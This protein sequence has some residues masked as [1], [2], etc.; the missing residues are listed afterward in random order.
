MFVLVT[1]NL[2]VDQ[3]QKEKEKGKKE[4]GKQK[5]MIERK[6]ARE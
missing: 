3:H 1:S 4:E 5:K 2:E 6:Q